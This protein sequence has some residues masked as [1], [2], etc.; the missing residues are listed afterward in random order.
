MTIWLDHETRCKSSSRAERLFKSV[1]GNT[2]RC[3]TCIM[4]MFREDM[5]HLEPRVWCQLLNACRLL[6]LSQRLA[7]S[8]TAIFGTF[9]ELIPQTLLPTFHGLASLLDGGRWSHFWSAASALG[10]DDEVVV[11][12]GFKVVLLTGSFPLMA[13]WR[14]CRLAIDFM[15]SLT[16]QPNREPIIYIRQDEYVCHKEYGSSNACDCA[17]VQ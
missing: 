13:L 3:M 6:L 8:P 11:V 7:L 17:P 12:N 10:T 14:E 4:D 2:A 1:E 15:S 16:I 5:F 9:L